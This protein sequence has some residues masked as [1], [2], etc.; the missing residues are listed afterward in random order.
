MEFGKWRAA[1]TT[2]LC[3]TARGRL[4][5]PCT[6]FPALWTRVCCDADDSGGKT[7][8]TD[9]G[10]SRSR[11]G[12]LVYR[13]HIKLVVV[14]SVGVG[15]T[16]LLEQFVNNRYTYAPAAGDS[17]PYTPLALWQGATTA[18]VVRPALTHTCG[19]P[20]HHTQ[21]QLQVDH[22]SRLLDN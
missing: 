8:D 5:R 13:R 11:S 6:A 9:G 18:S 4:S 22:R 2:H 1:R 17:S 20:T 12:S 15:K 7:D 19:T 3:P 14:G 16:S 21:R 10:R